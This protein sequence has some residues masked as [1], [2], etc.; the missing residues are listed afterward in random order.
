MKSKRWKAE[1]KAI[2]QSRMDLVEP[3]T[4]KVLAKV[5]AHRIAG[6]ASI[7]AE[8]KLSSGNQLKLEF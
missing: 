3:V 2:L 8:R 1:R 7:S 4:Y 6:R 5:N